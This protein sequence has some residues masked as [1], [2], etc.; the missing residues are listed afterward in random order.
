M[1]RLILVGIV[2][3]VVYYTGPS[4]AWPGPDYE[5]SDYNSQDAEYDPSFDSPF[6]INS[7]PEMETWAT[8]LRRRLQVEVQANPDSY[9]Q[10]DVAKVINGTDWHVTRYLQDLPGT[11]TAD[12]LQE[13][14]DLMKKTLAW[15][16]DW[17]MTDA[18]RPGE[19]PCEFYL[20]GEHH[21]ANGRDG[22]LVYIWEP[23]RMMKYSGEF[24]RDVYRFL[25]SQYDLLD[26]ASGF[27]TW[28]EMLTFKNMG[29]GT[30]PGSEI[31][32][33]L[34]D[35]M[36]RYPGKFVKINMVDLST[37]FAP[38]ELFDC[39]PSSSEVTLID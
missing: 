11:V 8:D 37:V 31:L 21:V 14:F 33:I 34:Y 20:T 15:R 36:S 25:H 27:S 5:S 28:T 10:V 22:G 9:D 12:G 7:S 39:S 24:S 17:R 19:F 32:N 29:Y 16:Q 35:M 38:G 18:D 13:R 30:V 4:L 26:E 23:S 3:Q 6:G 1:K 2:F